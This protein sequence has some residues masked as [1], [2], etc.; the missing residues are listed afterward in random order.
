[1]KTK[2]K[3]KLSF[4][5]ILFI[6]ISSINAQSFLKK[7]EQK[8]YECGYV[9]KASFFNKLKPM[10][11]IS[12]L[13]GGLVK[14]KPKSDLSDA[15]IAISYGSGLM[16]ESRLDF[17]TKVNGYETCGDAVSVV[18]LNYDGVGLTDTDG[19]VSLDG[20][21]LEKAGLGTYF[22]GFSPEK[23]G[24]KNI[25][26]TSSDGSKVSVDVAP[27][28]PIEIISVN[29]VEKGGDIILDG[30]KDVTI[31]L[32]GVE[33]DLDSE[34]YVEM[35]INAM[36]IKAQT[37]L[38]K[39]PTKNTIIVPKESFKNFEQSPL[40]IVEKNTLVVTR[41]KHKL[42]RNTDAGII[43]TI[44][45][46]SDF[47]PVLIEGDI[48][49]GSLITNSLSK[50]KNTEVSEKFKT[51]D[52][53]YKVKITKGNAYKYPPISKM[54]K[55]GISSFAVRG[56]LYYE[57][58]TT[59]ETSN[60]F[61]NMRTITTTT[62][63]KWFPELSDDTWQK[64]AD[65]MYN[66]LQEQFKMK[67]IEVVA[68]DKVVNAKAY[69]AM[70]A[71]QDTVSKTFVEKSAYGTK[72]LLKTGFFDQMADLKMTFPN[73]YTNE[74]IMKELDL[75]GLVAVTVDL[76]FN[77]KTNGLDPVVKIVA[78]SPNVTHRTPGQYFEMD[79]T[80]KTKSYAKSGKYPQGKPEIGIYNV[81]KGE[82]FNKAFGL[83]IEQLKEVE[84][85]FSVS[86]I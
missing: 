68:V 17:S 56:N 51:V 83:A 67:G 72:R 80:T 2:L 77:H 74:K 70:N 63:K 78:F 4:L 62:I 42:I 49:G 7:K 60:S 82:E 26:I 48:A 33:A 41:V 58:T 76:N 38:F 57:K 11:I 54:K 25:T 30:T 73:D 40:P 32:K 24:N 39:A 21:K 20:T 66:Q 5:V 81:I 3:F 75:D 13:A 61:T 44:G 59:S 9:H 8:S 43:Q 19:E 71:I 15:A 65:N 16:P 55:I 18:F 64:F 27:V 46:F 53:E 1:M 29:G 47:T 6:T 28:A 86:S 85:I 34:I 69:G 45:S 37:Y 31:E 36:S 12:K 10:K 23:R 22:Q 52:G 79:F 50:N 84:S 35:V 14:A